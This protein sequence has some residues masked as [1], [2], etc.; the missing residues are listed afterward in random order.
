MID[1]TRMR[2]A[3]IAATGFAIMLLIPLLLIEGALRLLPVNTGLGTRPVNASDPVYRFA[4]NRAFTYSK[5]WD[6]SLV[7]HGRTNNA[8]FVNDA[9]Y[10]PNAAGKLLAVVGDSYVEA[11]MVP[12]AQTINGRLAKAVA[13]AGR[14]YSFAASGAPLSQYLVWIAHAREQYRP[15]GLVV[16][17]VGNDFDESLRVLKSAPGF[18]YYDRG[19]GGAL[20]LA[21]I[22]YAPGLARRMVAATALGRY[23]YMNAQVTY[24]IPLVLN[25]VSSLFGAQPHPAHVA[26]TDARA[27]DRRLSLSKEAVD[28]FFRDL[29][30]AAGLPADRIHFVVDGIRYPN[31]LTPAVA[32]SYFVLMRD[33]FIQQASARGY[34]VTDMQPLFHRRHAQDGARFDYAPIDEHWNGIAHGL[35]AEAVTAGPVF[36]RVFGP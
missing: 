13:G 17:V 15:E 25:R 2:K 35:A 31:E 7:N 3:L 6:F 18:H 23:L 33:Y 26:N 36:H 29:P 30:Q 20:A 5:D 16:V 1:A 11:L 10:D 28:A 27:D 14:V 24:R 19:A 21:R 12:F 4:A 32:R 9:S 22:D 8:G 34:E